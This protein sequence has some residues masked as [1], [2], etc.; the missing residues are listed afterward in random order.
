MVTRIEFL[1]L[2]ICLSLRLSMIISMTFFVVLHNLPVNLKLCQKIHAMKALSLDQ[3][4]N[5]HL[6]EFSMILHNPIIKYLVFH[7]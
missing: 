2:Q 5:Y 6:Q 4:Q 3:S 7:A 1:I